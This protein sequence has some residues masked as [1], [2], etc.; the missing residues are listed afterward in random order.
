LKIYEEPFPTLPPGF[1]ESAVSSFLA[2]ASPLWKL[3]WLEML[4]CY[5]C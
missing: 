5:Q 4:P 3:L 2:T 1:C